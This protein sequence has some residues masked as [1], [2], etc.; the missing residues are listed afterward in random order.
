VPKRASAR[1]EHSS[2]ADR[3]RNLRA[4]MADRRVDAAESTRAFPQLA[5]FASHATVV[6]VTPGEALGFARGAARWRQLRYA[7]PHASERMRQRQAPKPDVAHAVMTSTAI[8]P[9]RRRLHRFRL[10]GGTDRQGEPL[11]VIVDIRR[12]I[13]VVVTIIGD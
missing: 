12:N 3:Q 10:S 4:L 2:L 9:D 13:V 1:F 7:E 11:S 6:Q 8:H 5:F